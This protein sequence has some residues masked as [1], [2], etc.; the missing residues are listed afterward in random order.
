[1]TTS[2]YQ[3]LQSEIVKLIPALRAFARRFHPARTDADDLVQETL[4]KALANLD[5]FNAGSSLKSWM[6]TIMRNSFCTKIK[7]AKREAPGV[8]ACVALASAVEPLQQTAVKMGELSAALDRLPEAQRSMVIDV[9]LHGES[10]EAI[11]ARTGCAV[12]TVKSRLN[13][14]RQHLIDELWLHD[15]I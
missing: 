13:R 7:L 10:Y 3:H 4:M 15:G 11:A 1:M 6:F 12:G 5:K 2:E 9:A 14:V 8:K